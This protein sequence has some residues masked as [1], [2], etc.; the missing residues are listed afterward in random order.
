MAKNEGTSPS[1]ASK[2]SKVRSSSIASKSARSVA[3]SA[4]TQGKDKKK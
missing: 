4:L 3:A 2:A 1:V